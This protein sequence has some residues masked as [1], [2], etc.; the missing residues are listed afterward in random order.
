MNLQGTNTP[1]SFTTEWSSAYNDASVPYVA[2]GGFSI[3]GV[4]KDATSLLFRF[5]KADARYDVSTAEDKS[6]D[7]TNAGKLLVSN[8]VDRRDPYT[9]VHSDKV[10]VKLTPSADG[11]Y[12]MVGNPF[13]A[14]LDVQAF[15]AANAANADNSGVAG[16]ISKV[17]D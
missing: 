5:P 6:V 7:R 14:P 16:R 2:G 11:K 4:L 12:L 3:K 10:T 9:Y 8:M 15:V 17:L 1:V 13:M